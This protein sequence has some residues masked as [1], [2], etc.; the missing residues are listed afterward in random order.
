MPNLNAGI[1]L[2]L[3][4]NDF[5]VTSHRVSLIA[6][7]TNRLFASNINYCLDCGPSFFG[8]DDC[9]VNLPKSRELAF[10]RSLA[11]E[12]RVAKLAEV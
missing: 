10:S 12:F 9:G 5:T 1:L 6:H 4:S 3:I 7:Q 8:A 2:D 11:T